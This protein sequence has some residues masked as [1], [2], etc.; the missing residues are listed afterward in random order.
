MK[1]QTLCSTGKKE[2]P[3]RHSTRKMAI[4]VGPK[5]KMS[6]FQ[7]APGPILIST[8]HSNSSQYDLRQVLL[9]KIDPF[10]T[11]RAHEVAVFFQWQ[12]HWYY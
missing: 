1:D 8:N 5:E 10:L 4:V 2:M 3:H 7:I 12:H 9:I 6:I 11:H